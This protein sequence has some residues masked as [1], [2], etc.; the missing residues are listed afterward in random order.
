MEWECD[1]CGKVVE[2]DPS[3]HD[4]TGGVITVQGPWCQECDIPMD[5]VRDLAE[6]AA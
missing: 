1:G 2:A 6:D 3:S 5:F 4:D